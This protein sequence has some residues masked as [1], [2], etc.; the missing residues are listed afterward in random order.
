MKSVILTFILAALA[1]P[2]GT[3]AVAS[4][5][6][7][8]DN[9]SPRIFNRHWYPNGAE[10]SRYTLKQAR[11]GSLHT[12]DA[13]LVFVTES[14]N[15]KTQIKADR[16]GTSDIPV[17][18]LNATRKFYTGIYPYS[19]MTSVF[20]PVG[21]ESVL[22]LKI[23]T[24]VQEWCGHVYM[25]LNLNQ[26][27][28]RLESHSYFE[29]EGDQ[30]VELDGSLP[31]DALWNRIRIAPASLPVGS[32]TLIPS[33]LFARFAHRQL[34][35]TA[36]TATLETAAGESLEGQPLMRYEVV[37]RNVDRLLVIG[38]EKAFPHRI[39]WWE[40]TQAGR[41]GKVLTTR[42]DRTHTVMIDYWNRHDPPDRKLLDRLGLSARQ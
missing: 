40:E 32:F 11:Y 26:N 16:P 18:K 35:P 39:Q 34:S 10:I 30:Q 5:D 31:E 41:D 4:A 42:A 12:G 29:G 37:Y 1:F 19:L 15:P 2:L 24:T 21:G 25:Q 8:L 36:V 7:R 23:S 17:L 28:Y 20:T 6:I 13:V 38:F 27:R 3:A 33:T 14:M 9:P 22:P